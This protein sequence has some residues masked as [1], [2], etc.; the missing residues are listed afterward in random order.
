MNRDRLG[1][2]VGLRSWNMQKPSFDPGLTQQF[3][4][5]L[6]RAINKDGSFNVVRR[7]GSWRNIH[8]YLHLINIGWTPFFAIVFLT[9]ILV[10]TCFAVL[11]FGLAPG[12]LQGVESPTGFGR[13][14]NVFFFSAHTLTTVGYGNFA[15]IGVTANA[16]AAIEAMVGLM[17]FALATG[18]LFGRVA[19][20]SA[21]IG[22]S[23]NA[24]LTPY[25]DRTSLQF[26]LVNLRS[27]V[28]IDLQA[29]V[30]LMTV[31]GPPGQLTR[32]FRPLSLERDQI[33]FFP[34]TWTVV[35]PINEESPL[36]NKSPQEL[37]QLQAEVL[38]LIKGFDDTFSQTVNARYSYR[39]D[40]FAWG[41]KFRPAFEIDADGQMVVD[42]DRVGQFAS[43]KQVS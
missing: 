10:N 8:P 43:P 21:K 29:S 34:L 4:G 37:E 38:I 11:Y 12:E 30:L 15:P 20:P 39:Y 5:T 2:P 23:E 9:Y 35:H 36:F 22:F 25:Q 24:L 33:Y 19:K 28:L 16:L 32:Q 14:L 3:T 27:N 42:V 40:E 7:G 26:R 41:A 17:G 18:L 1:V 31:E 6:R 13:F